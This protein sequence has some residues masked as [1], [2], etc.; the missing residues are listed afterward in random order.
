LKIKNRG[1]SLRPVTVIA[2][3][4][5]GQIFEKS[6][7]ILKGSGLVE[8][9]MTVSAP[10]TSIET[11]NQI[12]D[13][14]KTDYFLFLLRDNIDLIKES[15]L[16]RV[17]EEAKA[18]KAGIVYSDYHEEGKEGK[19][20]HPLIDYQPGSVRDDFDFSAMMLFSTEAVRSAIKKYG[21]TPPVKYAGLYDIRL[22]VSI[23]NPVCHINEPLY[24][25]VESSEDS[26][27]ERHFAYV[28]PKNA[29]VQG[30]MEIVFTGYLK[31]IGAYIP[32]E[33]LRK[34][35]ETGG[36]FPVEASVVIP[37]RNRA[38]TI[39]D[40]V[41]SALSQKT[42][43]S[44]NVIVVDNHSEDGTTAVLS[45]MA[46]NCPQLLHIIPER[47]DLGIGGCWNEA[48]YSKECGRFIVQLDSDDLY[49]SP[50][51]LQ[52][53]VDMLRNGSYAMVIG[54]YTIVDFNLNVIPPSLSIIMS[55]RMR[56]ATTTPCALTALVL[57][58]PLIQTLSDRLVFS[59]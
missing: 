31:K 23:D 35:F 37:V 30:Q 17:L 9:V 11:L 16:E 7:K 24:S 15:A 55:G 43:F 1:S 12:S 34:A 21:A 40:A 29:D 22:K 14:V 56:T 6:Q 42:N 50:L 32:P 46:G 19:K 53:I 36:Q 2:T 48:L 49:S 26:A 38:G 5:K 8:D 27:G 44:F 33:Y 45:A 28:D 54:S 18:K 57:P 39:S 20:L 52:K 41:K 25:V 51:T 10:L 58:V 13:E 59:M 47:T 3:C 4:Q